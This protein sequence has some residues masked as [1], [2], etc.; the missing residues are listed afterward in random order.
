M[1]IS[2]GGL[3]TSTGEVYCQADLFG[4]I[5]ESA[6]NPTAL[7][8]GAVDCIQGES[9]KPGRPSAHCI[10]CE[11]GLCLPVQGLAGKAPF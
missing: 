11:K 9:T 5:R 10:V 7:G 4:P 3:V 6:W 2:G 8:W 1:Q